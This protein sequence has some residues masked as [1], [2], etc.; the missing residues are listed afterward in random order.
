MLALFYFPLWHENKWTWFS[1]PSPA[2]YVEVYRHVSFLIITVNFPHIAKLFFDHFKKFLCWDFKVFILLV[3]D[4]CLFWI[5]K[6]NYFP[7]NEITSLL[8]SPNCVGYIFIK[9]LRQKKS[10]NFPTHWWLLTFNIVLFSTWYGFQ[11][12]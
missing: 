10:Y 3:L 12:Q 8:P 2:F 7:P 4:Y 1:Y 5:V 9:F 11:N 6:Q